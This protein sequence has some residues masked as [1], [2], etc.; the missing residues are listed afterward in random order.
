MIVGLLLL[1]GL[2]VFLGVRSWTYSQQLA[3]FDDALRATPGIHVTAVERDGP[4]IT[5]RGLRD[6]LAASID[7]IAASID[8]PAARI[9][10]DLQPFQSLQPEI[11]AARAAELFSKPDTVQFSVVETTLV[12]N[13]TAPSAWKDQLQAGFKSLAGVNALDLSGFT[14]EVIRGADARHQAVVTRQAYR[15]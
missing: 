3:K 6:P 7:D 1:A 8:I 5:L 9:S 13:G 11:I 10:A 4:E 14:A 15:S 2:L 12:V